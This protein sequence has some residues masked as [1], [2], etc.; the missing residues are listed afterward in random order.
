MAEFE[1]IPDFGGFS[2][3]TLPAGLPYQYHAFVY[4]PSII[5][6]TAFTWTQIPVSMIIA[7]SSPQVILPGPI[8]SIHWVELMNTELNIAPPSPVTDFSPSLEEVIT[9]DSIIEIIA[10]PSVEGFTMVGALGIICNIDATQTFTT[11]IQLAVEALELPM[12]SGESSG[13]PCAREYD[14]INTGHGCDTTSTLLR[15]M[16]TGN[17]ANVYANGLGISCLKDPITPHLMP[18][19]D[20]CGACSPPPTTEASSGTVYVGGKLV[21]RMGDNADANIAM[22]SIITGSPNV[23][24]G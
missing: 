18:I 17:T 10:N 16:Q 4:P 24:V 13:E 11:Y 2:Y 5:L 7:S 22:G 20:S 19:G 14:M 3:D 9:I 8:A 23:I 15:S 6:G 12:S 1:Y 21:S